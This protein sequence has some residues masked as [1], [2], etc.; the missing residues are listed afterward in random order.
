MDTRIL[1]EKY[2]HFKET[3]PESYDE[4]LYDDVAINSGIDKIFAITKENNKFREL[5]RLA[6]GHFLSEDLEIGICVLFTYDYFSDFIAFYE[7]DTNDELYEKLLK[8][9]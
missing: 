1:E 5:Y 8:R 4:L 3:D 2:A 6:A 9:L 7:N